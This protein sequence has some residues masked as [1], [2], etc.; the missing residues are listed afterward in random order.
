MTARQI[1]TNATSTAA[2]TAFFTNSRPS[3]ASTI[4]GASTMNRIG[5]AAAEGR[6]GRHRRRGRDRLREHVVHDSPPVAGAGSA[7]VGVTPKA[8]S[9][10]SSGRYFATQSTC[11]GVARVTSP[12]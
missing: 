1:I 3:D 4:S 11:S 10:V 12:R 5:L 8:D 2:C 7:A 6:V 9:E